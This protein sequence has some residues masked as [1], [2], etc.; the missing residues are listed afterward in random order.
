[1]IF[2]GGSMYPHNTFTGGKYRGKTLE[3]VSKIDP[4]Y[5]VWAVRVT[6]LQRS[7]TDKRVDGPVQ[8]IKQGTTPKPI[9]RGISRSKVVEMRYKHLKIE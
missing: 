1:M 7:S 6:G 3:Y 2:K 5:I 4:M 8:E 9:I